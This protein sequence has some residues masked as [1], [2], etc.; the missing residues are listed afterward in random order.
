MARIR[1]AHGQVAVDPVDL[2]LLTFIK[3]FCCEGVSRNG[4]S[5]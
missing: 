1:N 3:R 4:E 5:K 2:K